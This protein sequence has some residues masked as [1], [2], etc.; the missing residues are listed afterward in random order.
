M[1]L[2]FRG[3]ITVYSYFRA[4]PFFLQLD[5]ILLEVGYHDQAV[6][7]DPL[8]VFADFPICHCC[9]LSTLRKL[10]DDGSM[11]SMDEND[12]WRLVRQIIE[13]L[14]YI[15]K[16]NIIHRDLVGTFLPQRFIGL[17]IN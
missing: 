4:L 2:V 16:R 5:G 7:T 11:R 9:R 8:I 12:I 15:H 10:I 1:P 3:C 17:L 13:A 14:V 6:S